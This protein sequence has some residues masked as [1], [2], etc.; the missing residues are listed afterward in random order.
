MYAEPI[1]VK[2]TTEAKSHLDVCIV[3]QFVR[4]GEDVLIRGEPHKYLGRDG[5]FIATRSVT[6]TIHK[7]DLDALYLSGHIKLS[8][9]GQRWAKI[10]LSLFEGKPDGRNTARWVY[11]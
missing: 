7:F 5:W 11:D 6:G 4:P 2:Y 8:A 3:N 10:Y 9:L 1:T